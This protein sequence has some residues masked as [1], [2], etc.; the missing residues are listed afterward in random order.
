MLQSGVLLKEI[1][2]L[3]RG[4]D[5]GTPDGQLKS[6]ACAL[7]FLIGQL[8]H[9]GIGD[10]GLRATAPMI[11]DLLVE[12]LA[13]DG[14]RLRKDVPR[15]LEELVEEGRL[16][17]LTATS[18]GF[19][20]RKARS[21]RRTSTSAEP[22]IH[23]DAARMSQLRNE[24][25]LR[26]GRRGAGWHEARPRREQ[27]AA[28]ASTGSGETTSQRSTAGRSRSGSATG[29][30]CPEAKVKEAAA[31]AGVDSPVVHVL[32]PRRRRRERSA[33]RSP[34][35]PP[36]RTRST[37]GPSRRPTRAAR[38]SRACSR[39]SRTASGASTSSSTR[40][41]A[42]ARVFQG[43]GNELIRSSLRDARR[44]C[45][46]AAHS[47]GL[48]PKFGVADNPAWDKVITQGARRRA[49]CA[50][51][52]R[53]DG[54]GAGE[55]RLQGGARPDLGRRHEAA[56]TF[57]DSSSSPTYG[58]PQDAI[59]GALLALLANGNIRAER[60]GHP[61]AGPKELPPTQ[62]GKA[63]FFKEDEPPST[64]ERMAV[65][66]VLTEAR[67]PYTPGRK[68]PRSAGCCSTSWISPSQAGG[69]APLPEP[70]DISHVEGLRALAGNQQFRAVAKQSEQLRQD[71]RLWATAGEQRATREAAWANSRAASQP[72]D[73]IW[74]ARPTVER[75]A[76]RSSGTGS[77]SL[78]PIRWHRS[79]A[80]L[81]RTASRRA[82]RCS[83][84]SYELST[85]DTSRSSRHPP[86]GK[87][88]D[89]S[90]R[91]VD[92]RPRRSR[93]RP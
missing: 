30:T 48:F 88:L 57:S 29:G 40:V 10:T 66:G 76:T 58:W 34:A 54:R 77:S 31:A 22:P 52:S 61:V 68:A 1:D 62:I 49:R 65:R 87:Q 53:L 74:T 69:P 91:K 41:V 86:S 71:I 80:Q 23:D 60:D 92:S 55:P 90:D 17:K 75:S 33:T 6:R 64:T 84:A 32:L 82:H 56:A 14:E 28:E 7:V 35:M 8:P 2:E 59:N 45:R 50:H 93:R 21:G 83:R 79:S 38:R 43:G 89:E 3:I 63:T 25:L 5:D 36:R 27:D 16:V 19:R 9:E 18:S 72:R 4:L 15:V 81:C 78:I 47:R 85:R 67:I 26:V 20:P 44:G 73:R 12:D 39:G 70:P 51:G 37:S 11:A 13:S 24:W 46:R 42:S